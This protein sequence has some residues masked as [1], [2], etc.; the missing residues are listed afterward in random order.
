MGGPHAISRPLA[1]DPSQGTAYGAAADTAVL[2]LRA[3]PPISSRRPQFN[4]PHPPTLW[5]HRPA[6]RAMHIREGHQLLMPPKSGVHTHA[7]CGWTAQGGRPTHPVPSAAARQI[8]S[9]MPPPKQHSGV[10]GPTCGA[11]NQDALGCLGHGCWRDL[12]SVRGRAALT[13]CVVARGAIGSWGSGLFSLTTLP[14]AVGSQAPSVQTTHA[15]NAAFG[16]HIASSYQPSTATTRELLLVRAG[17][18]H[19]WQGP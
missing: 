10:P 14:A 12:G 16:T 4:L 13:A 15:Q 11:S 9:Q 18:S 7:G 2:P 1:H 19:A 5:P 17:Y 3:T 6:R 8:T